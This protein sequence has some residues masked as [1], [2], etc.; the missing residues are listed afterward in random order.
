MSQKTFTIVHMKHR[1]LKV[2]PKDNVLVAL[3]NLKKGETISFEGENYVLQDDINAKHK[4]F[5]KDLDT[6][7]E[8][9]MYGVLV[10]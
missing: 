7:E 9:I 3:S 8:V 1:V 10:G 2:N 5:T 4:F 6:G